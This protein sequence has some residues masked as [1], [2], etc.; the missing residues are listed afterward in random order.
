MTKIVRLGHDERD[1]VVGLTPL[2]DGPADPDVSQ[3]FLDTAGH[4]LL[5]A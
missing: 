4:V 2:F 1:A 5:V 3:R